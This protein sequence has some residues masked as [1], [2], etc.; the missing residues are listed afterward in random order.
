MFDKVMAS[1]RIGAAEVDTLLDKESV[2]PGET[3]PVR[4]VVEGGEVDQEIDEIDLELKAKRDVDDV[5][6]NYEIRSWEVARDFVIQEDEERVFD[7]E[8]QI[9]RETPVTTVQARRQKSRVWIDTDLDIE[10]AIDADDTDYLDVEPTGP[11]RAMLD[12]VSGAGH[13]LY[14]VS[15]DNDRIRAGDARAQLPIDQEFVFKPTGSASYKEI[16]IH[17]LPRE[18]ATHV[19]VEFDYRVGSEEFE[20]LTIDHADYSVEGLQREFE[21]L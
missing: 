9:H 5:T 13:E 8:L 21:R 6:N 11:M 2:E 18:T 20:V 14:E 12:A 15:V 10:K 19:L 1:V 7:A 17:F 3:L 4:V 16:E